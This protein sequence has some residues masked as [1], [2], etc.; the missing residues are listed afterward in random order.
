M[1]R[2][3]VAAVV[4]VAALVALAPAV[5][6]AALDL[7]WDGPTLSL[8]WDGALVAGAEQSFVGVPVTVPGDRARRAVSVRNDGPTAGTLRAWVEQ[9]D[10]LDPAPGTDDGFYDDLRLDWTTVSQSDGAS[11]RALDAAGSTLIA[12]THL[13]Q[14]AATRVEVG[15]E[16]PLAA[17][18]GNR[19]VVGEREASF[20]VRFQITGDT[21]AATPTPGSTAL[22]PGSPP[23]GVVAGA[24]A[25]PGTAALALTGLDALRAALL[26]VVAI[27][28]GST[29]LGAARRRRD[30]QNP[31]GSGTTPSA[32]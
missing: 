31:G 32:G 20:V 18:T 23:D 26:A 4:T 29:L 19:T 30:V 7:A 8:A 17:T 11:F 25:T 15:Y 27:G 24:G 14:G 3:R 21:T 13:A 22:P 12:Q 16:L 5:P 28:V 1:S 9:V 6:A 10:L 2:A